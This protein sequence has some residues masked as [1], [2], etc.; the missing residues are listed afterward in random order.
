MVTVTYIWKNI[1]YTFFGSDEV[2]ASPQM[3]SQ[4]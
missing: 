4:P 3:A 1:G 2:W